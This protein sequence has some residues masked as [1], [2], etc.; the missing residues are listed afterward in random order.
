MISSS[1]DKPPVNVS[2]EIP[3]TRT[4]QID[5]EQLANLRNAKNIKFGDEEESLS[6]PEPFGS[7]GSESEYLSNGESHSSSIVPDTPENMLSSDTECNQVS[8]SLPVDH[9][10]NFSS[11]ETDEETDN[12]SF[13]VSSTMNKTKTK[14]LVKIN[15]A[16]KS[17][18]GKRIRNKDHS[19]YFCHKLLR[20]LA[21]H[22]ERAHSNETEVARIL[23][24][25]INSKKRREAFNALTRNGDFYHNCDVLLLE[26]GELILTRRPTEQERRF[27]KY[28]DYGPCPE[29]LGFMIKRN[30]WH[31]LKYSCICMRNKNI[32]SCEKLSRLPAAESTALLNGIY[33]H[34]MT[35]DFRSNILNKMRDDEISKICHRDDLILRFG[36]F[37]YEKYSST[38]SEL[39]RQSMRQLGR[40]TIEIAKKNTDVHRLIDA[41]VPEK[42]DAVVSATKSLC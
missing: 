25:P 19:C 38:Q 41:L 12:D 1:S 20:N 4:I 42:F 7:G 5:S 10:E 39:I 22:F 28:S 15:C 9:S 21:R 23:S 37:I 40:L 16:K 30:L 33:G 35:E 11:M 29:C 18:G 8:R 17:S 24:M 36:A 26:K 32:L 31:H 6:E 3:L 13:G 34:N 14:E 2:P 27:L